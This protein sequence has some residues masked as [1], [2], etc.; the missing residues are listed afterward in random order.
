M[1][2]NAA[3]CLQWETIVCSDNTIPSDQIIEYP[4]VSNDSRYTFS[5]FA[6]PED[7][8]PAAITD[9]FKFCKDYYSEKGDTGR[10]CCTWATASR[11]IDSRSCL[12]PGT[13]Q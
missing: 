6:F 3:W 1:H 11:R 13:E 7:E 5:L 8:Y 2:L 12:T 10:T 9:F 4:P